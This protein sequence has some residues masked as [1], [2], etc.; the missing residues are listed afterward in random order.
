[1]G[2][3]AIFDTGDQL[4]FSGGY[5]ARMPVACDNMHTTVYN[6]HRLTPYITLMARSVIALRVFFYLPLIECGKASRW[7]T[8]FA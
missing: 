1:A 3:I 2:I 6:T 7:L 5:L 4:I 8:R